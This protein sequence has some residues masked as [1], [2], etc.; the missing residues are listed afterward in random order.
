[1]R[2]IGIEP[3]DFYLLFELNTSQIEHLLNF[4]DRC[5]VEYDSD[6]EKHMKEA[7]EYVTE[8]FFK[9]LNQVSEELKKK[10]QLTDEDFKLG[11][12]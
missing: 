5:T 12:K 1:M 9:Q 4:L 8:D 3:R 10:P 11:V 2:I 6:K 7:S